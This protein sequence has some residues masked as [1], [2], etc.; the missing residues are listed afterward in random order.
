MARSS[1]VSSIVSVGYTTHQKGQ[2][3]QE[4][5][6]IRAHNGKWYMAEEVGV[7]HHKSR[8]DCPTYGT[9]TL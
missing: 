8:A 7:F 1:T 5:D 4:H 9:C 2:D 6:V 3:I